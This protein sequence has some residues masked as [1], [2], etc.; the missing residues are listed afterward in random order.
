M[1]DRAEQEIREIYT[2]VD[3][4]VAEQDRDCQARTT[5][6]HFLLTGKTP[7]LTAGE[8]LVAAKAVR[9]SG[10]KTLP[11]NKDPHSGRCPLLGSDKRCTIYAS[12][13]IGCR[14]H[15]CKQAGGPL[16]R[17]ILQTLIHRLEA[18]SES[19]AD[20]DPR[21]LGVAIT[22]ALETIRNRR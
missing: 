9:A 17:R 18:I 7:M 3:R 8:A 2:E 6:C 22:R 4:L 1:S 10:R 13:P 14:T 5:C 11:S 16:P 21:P 19:L 15:F 20:T 12:R